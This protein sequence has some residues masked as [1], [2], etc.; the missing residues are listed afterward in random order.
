MQTLQMSPV[1]L[2]AGLATGLMAT[3]ILQV[4]NI[5]DMEEDRMAGKKTLVV[6]LGSRF[7]IGLW[8]F[9]IV[10]AALIPLE[11]LVATAEHEWAALTL[12]SPH[13][14]SGRVSAV[15]YGNQ[16]GTADSASWHDRDCCSWLTVFC[17]LWAGFLA[18]A[19][20][21]RG[22]RLSVPRAAYRASVAR[23]R[24]AHAS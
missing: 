16:D 13:T 18:N 17:F 22:P 1:V 12:L 9:C 8:A 5:R 15:T 7:G 19:V 21:R 10:A 3:A 4:N 2:V 24:L 23:P 14:G 20:G 11:L 6:R